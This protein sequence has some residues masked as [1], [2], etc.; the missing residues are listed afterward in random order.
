MT[1]DCRRT[2]VT[3]LGASL[4][5]FGTS[6][7]AS[8]HQKPTDFETAASAEQANVSTPAGKAF[9]A[10][11]GEEF[12]SRHV[13]TMTRCTLRLPAAGLAPFVVLLRLASDGKVREVLV[14]PA[15]KVASCLQLAVAKEKYSKPPR[16]NYWV[17]IDMSLGQ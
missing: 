14:R 4:A 3:I 17:R 1:H 10:A 5:M 15:T 7:P 8:G 6:L 13:N 16:D 2:V 11:I 12:A 9:D